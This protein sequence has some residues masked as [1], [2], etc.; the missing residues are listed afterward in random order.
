MNQVKRVITEFIGRVKPNKTNIDRM[1]KD[2]LIEYIE[3]SSLLKIYIKSVGEE[4]GARKI[5]SFLVS[6]SWVKIPYH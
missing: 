3:N 4:T 5:K 1:T 2:Q 6:K